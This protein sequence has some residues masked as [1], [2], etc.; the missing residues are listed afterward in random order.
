VNEMGE[1]CDN[2]L[3]GLW[4]RTKTLVG[5]VFLFSRDRQITIPTFKFELKF[6][7]PDPRKSRIIAK[8]DEFGRISTSKPPQQ[9]IIG[10]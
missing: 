8:R 1:L 5:S 7:L 10:L 6:K 3:M 2:W 4:A 9:F